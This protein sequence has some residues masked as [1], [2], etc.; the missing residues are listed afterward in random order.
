MSSVTESA[1]VTVRLSAVVLIS[2]P[3]ARTRTRASNFNAPAIPR[4]EPFWPRT[5][6]V[7]RPSVA[8]VAFCGVFIVAVKLTR[9]GW[10]AVSRTT[11]T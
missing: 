7:S 10:S 4:A 3:C 11:T 1:A 8:T 2:P 9:P 6:S 5:A